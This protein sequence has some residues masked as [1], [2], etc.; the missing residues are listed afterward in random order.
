MSTAD[1]FGRIGVLMGGNSSERPISL[2]SGKAVLSALE[3]KGLVVVPLDIQGEQRQI[4]SALEEAS[5]D[6]AFITLHGLGGEDGQ[7]QSILEELDIPYIGSSPQGSLS[8]YNKLTAKKIFVEH[9]MLTP[10]YAT[11]DSDGW[12]REISNFPFPVFVK[13][14]EEGSSIGVKKISSFREAQNLI[15][16]LFKS[17]SELLLEEAVIGREL[18]VG[19]LADKALPVIELKPRNEFYDYEAKY[20]KGL[21]EYLIPAPLEF[22]VSREIQSVALKAHRALGLRDFSRVDLILSETGE[23][24]ILE[25]NT[26]P[27]FTETS[28]LPKAAKEAGIEFTDLCLTLLQLTRERCSS[29]GKKKIESAAVSRLNSHHSFQWRAI[30]FIILVSAYFS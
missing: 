9:G 21:T 5:L 1:S 30:L 8:A 4:I 24:H 26:I 29:Y 28:L 6:V 16:Q 20:T 22:R 15:P 11:I 2:R 13:P 3:A 12:H 14:I 18:T 27:G 10:N 7:I 19:I 23:I 17:Y 25:V